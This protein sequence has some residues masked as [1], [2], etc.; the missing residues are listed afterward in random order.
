MPGGRPAKPLERKRKTGRAPG[1][2]SGGRKL[3]EV[4][5]VVALP[6]AGDAPEPPVELGLA[7]RELWSRVWACG[8]FLDLAGFGLGCGCQG[9]PVEGCRGVDV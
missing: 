4:A 1:R 2:D 7:G 9:V 5:Q 6:M 3:P 8:D